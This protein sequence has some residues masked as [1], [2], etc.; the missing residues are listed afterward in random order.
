MVFGGCW[1]VSW[2]AEE[3]IEKD[4]RLSNFVVRDLSERIGLGG[5]YPSGHS[6]NSWMA[7]HVTE[8]SIFVQ[9]TPFPASQGT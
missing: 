8:G 2:F 4:A 1:S 5:A 6:E 3:S 7:R 9:S